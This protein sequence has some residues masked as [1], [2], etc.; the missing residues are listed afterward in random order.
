[1]TRVKNLRGSRC[2]GGKS[3]PAI[4]A[5]KRVTTV[6]QRAGSNNG[7]TEE[8]TVPARSLGGEAWSTKL[9]RINLRSAAN[10]LM[11]FNNLGH[12]IDLKM[13][14]DC[15]RELDG[16]KAV[17]IDGVTK[18]EY[19]QNLEEN[20]KALLTSVRRGTY[21]PKPSK[22]VEIPKED[23]SNRPLLISC[24]EDKIIQL[25]MAKI[26][27]AIY[28]PIFLPGSYGFRPG[29]SAHD[30]LKDLQSQ[31]F[32]NTN[33]A[34]I[35]IDL[36]QYFN[37][38]PQPHLEEMLKAKITDSRFL[39]LIHTLLKAPT[40][41]KDGIVPNTTG[42][43]QGSICSPILAN[44][45]LHY[46]IDQWVEDTK[47]GGHIQ[48][49]FNVIRFADDLVFSFESVREAERFFKVLPKRLAK[50]G[51]TMNL[52]KSSFQPGGQ[53][54]ITKGQVPKP[55]FKF[56]GFEVRWIKGR[57]GRLRPAYNPRLDRM[58]KRLRE[59]KAFLWRNLNAP[60]HM[61]ILKKVDAVVRGWVNYFAI[62][63]CSHR[64]WRFIRRVRHL[65]HKWFN[66]RGGNKYMG[67]DK[68]QK[69]LD[70][71]GFT[72]QFNIRSV[73][74]TREKQTNH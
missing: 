61:E 74:P 29:R 34:V 66:R 13:M 38:I 7:T 67:W 60:D 71:A 62:S 51:L 72:E 20:L 11:V 47:A 56:L 5:R 25:A 50:Y 59:V 23:G 17:G 10:G 6:E 30:A 65:I 44:I 48:G 53:A 55:R 41:T 28:E 54:S 40:L 57:N 2:L 22:I 32:R 69:V 31:M 16:K 24:L 68:V 45:Y 4:G 19:G 15:Y 12:I 58:N 52:E 36:K 27:E 49:R 18:L 3:E 21:T 64:V 73:F 70:A 39:G 37:T 9:R 33:G 42:V 35:E 63:D 8:E 1:M 46:V 43:P 14:F 26:L